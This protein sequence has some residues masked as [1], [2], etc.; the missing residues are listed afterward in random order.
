MPGILMSRNTRSGA[1]RSAIVS[2]S[3]PVARRGTR[4]PRIR[5][6]S[7]ASRGWPAS[8]SM[9]RMR[10]FIARRAAGGGR[11]CW[12]SDYVAEFG[13]VQP[14][15][16][17][18]SAPSPAC[19]PRPAPASSAVVFLLTEPD[20]L[21]PSRSSAASASSR[22]MVASVPV[23]T[24]VWPATAARRAARRQGRGHVARRPR[25]SRSISAW[26]AG[27]VEPGRAPTAATT[28]PTSGD[29]LELLQRGGAQGRAS[30]EGAGQRRRAA[31]A[32]VADAERV[33]ERAT[34]RRLPALV[35]LAR[36]GS[37][38]TSCPS[39]RAPPAVSARR[40]A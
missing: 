28:G 32:D 25:P 18:A 10:G 4:S 17:P 36:R 33:D 37:P 14:R 2:P 8:S 39:A 12:L 16:R 7:A 15:A 21:A 22:V 26:F 24:Q 35:D 31:L 23:M 40:G 6:S 20:T 9:T 30:A 3:W 11:A 34:A 19:C 27:V 38:P 5:G 1:S 13:F 29:R